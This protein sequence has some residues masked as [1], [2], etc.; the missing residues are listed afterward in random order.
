MLDTKVIDKAAEEMY[1]QFISSKPHRGSFL[2]GVHA[3]AVWAEHELRLTW[4]AE[5]PTVPGWYWVDRGFGAYAIYINEAELEYD[6]PN[7][8]FAGPIPEPAEPTQG[9][10]EG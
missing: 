6:R 8:R 2:G 3:G 10:D 5:R 9:G 4:T 1:G 7:S